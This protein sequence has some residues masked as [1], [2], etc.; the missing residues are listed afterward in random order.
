MARVACSAYCLLEKALVPTG[1]HED[2]LSPPCPAPTHSSAWAPPTRSRVSHSHEPQILPTQ[3]SQ[4]RPPPPNAPLLSIRALRARAQ[5]LQR[6]RTVLGHQSRGPKPF[7]PPSPPPPLKPSQNVREYL[8]HPAGSPQRD[9][10]LC[11]ANDH[12]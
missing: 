10:A 12:T 4:R 5:P 7:P 2:P 6:E 9:K 3:P 8:K 1:L 11:H